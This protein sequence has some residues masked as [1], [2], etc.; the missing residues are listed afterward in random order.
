MLMQAGNFDKITLLDH[1]EQLHEFFRVTLHFEGHSAVVFV[2]DPT[3]QFQCLCRIPGAVTKTDALHLTA[4]GIVPPDS[5]LRKS[6]V[7][8]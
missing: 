3:G 5:S 7:L 1:G 2:L 6:S 8:K 4:D